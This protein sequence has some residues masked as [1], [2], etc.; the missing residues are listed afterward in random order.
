MTR[1][2]ARAVAYARNQFE[3]VV[4]YMAQLGINKPVHIGETGW[5]SVDGSAYG[6]SG[7]KAADE[8]KQKLFHDQLRDWTD[9][10]GISLF[11]FEAFDEQWKNAHSPSHSE[12]HF[13]LITLNNEVK[14]AL[15]EAFDEGRFAQLTRD[16]KPLLKSFSGNKDL[17]VASAM[18]PPF[19]SQMAVREISTVNASRSVGEKVTEARLV[20]VH[21]TLPAE[22]L[23]TTFPSAKLKLVP[24]EG[25]TAIELMPGGVVRVETRAG[26]WW[27]ASLQLDSENGENLSA[28]ED[29]TLNFEI[30]GSS[31]VSFG[32]G[33]QTGNFLRGDQVNN[34]ANIGAGTD[35]TIGSE[36]RKVAISISDIEG[37]SGMTDVTNLIAFLGQERAPEREIF[38]R[39]IYFSQQ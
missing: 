14:Y 35:I 19:K 13:G 36:W 39:N 31:D 24:W 29:G 2:M 26:D 10:A 9:E 21:D 8:Y 22:S 38:L 12:N 27:G 28:F 7:S 33:F 25:T 15:W 37:G 23:D 18:L 32:L 4:D 20:I 11:F 5:A 6:V 17:L 3:S 1:T 30:R 16:G 34:F